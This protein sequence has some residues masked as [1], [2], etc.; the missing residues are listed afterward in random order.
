MIYPCTKPNTGIANLHDDVVKWKHFPRYCPFVWGIHRSPVNSPHKGQWR[1]ALMF[2]LICVWKNGW[3][4]K[5]EAGDLRRYRAHYDVT[6]MQGNTFLSAI[7]QCV[8]GGWRMGYFWK[9][10]SSW[11]KITTFVSANLVE[12]LA[13][14]H[15][16]QFLFHPSSPLTQPGNQGLECSR[17][18]YEISDGAW[19]TALII[20]CACELHYWI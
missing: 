10:D 15:S 6:V 12:R 20:F 7:W 17:F 14:L 3:V 19:N 4:N 13:S 11:L 5:H 16:G 9:L 18:D 1:G 2:S 8:S